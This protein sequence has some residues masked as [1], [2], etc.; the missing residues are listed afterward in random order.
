MLVRGLVANTSW[1]TKEAEGDYKRGREIE[2]QLFGSFYI[3]LF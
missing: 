2:E 1:Q 3:F